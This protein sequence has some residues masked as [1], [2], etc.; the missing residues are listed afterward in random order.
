MRAR[1]LQRLQCG[2]NIALNGTPC[3][4]ALAVVP[5]A[6]ITRT[7]IRILPVEVLHSVA[8]EARGV[9]AGPPCGW[10]NGS[11]IGGRR[12]G[13]RSGRGAC[14]PL[15]ALWTHSVCRCSPSTDAEAGRSVWRERER[16]GR[17]IAAGKGQGGGGENGGGRK[18]HGSEWALPG[19]DASDTKLRVATFNP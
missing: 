14:D 17:A 3:F 9:G 16:D 2:V 6:D 5:R 15:V 11:G 19:M 12:L 10:R 4:V 8:R 7:A 13:L 1:R 18:L